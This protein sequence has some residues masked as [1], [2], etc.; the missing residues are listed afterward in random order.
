M[1]Y[2]PPRT[3]L[4]LNIQTIHQ[5]RSTEHY[6]VA[7]CTPTSN[8]DSPGIRLGFDWGLEG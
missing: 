1:S 2:T 6:S 7:F 4:L 3:L 5:S 8:I